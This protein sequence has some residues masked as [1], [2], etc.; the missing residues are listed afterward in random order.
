MDFFQSYKLIAEYFSCP[1]VTFIKE[2]EF[3]FKEDLYF[4]NLQLCNV[5]PLGLLRDVPYN[6]SVSYYGKKVQ[7]LIECGNCSTAEQEQLVEVREILGSV[8][9]YVQ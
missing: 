6:E 1:K 5:Y 8:S 3:S 4:P 2:H 9:G 7:Q